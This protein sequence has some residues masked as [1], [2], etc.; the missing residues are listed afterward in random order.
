MRA[1]VALGTQEWRAGFEQRRN[2]G[3][4]RGMTIGAVLRHWFMFP[5]EGAAL[6]GMA[7]KAGLHDRALLQQMGTGRTVRVVAVGTDH[8]AFTDRMVRN[9]TAVRSLFLVT[10]KADLGLGGLFADRIFYT[11]YIVA[12]C[13]GIIRGSMRTHLPIRLDTTL[14]A[15]RTNG[16][17]L[18]GCK[19][20]LGNHQHRFLPWCIQMLAHGAVAGLTAAIGQGHAHLG[21]NK[22]PDVFFVALDTLFSA[23]NKSRPFDIRVYGRP[24]D[25]AFILRN[26]IGGTQL[27]Q[28]GCGYHQV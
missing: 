4:V 7:D 3:S 1:V 13:A 16:I 26:R 2:I 20:F 11:H 28:D 23:F 22:G 8:L 15:L 21:S 17:T 27:E 19:V 25:Y 9:F 14:M 18:L 10:G 6:F 24:V 5:Q 12:V